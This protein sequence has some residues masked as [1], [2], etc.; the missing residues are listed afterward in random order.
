MDATI[1]ISSTAIVK[2][3]TGN[4]TV[5]ISE[6][7]EAA[8]LQ[9]AVKYDVNTLKVVSCGAG[10]LASNAVINHAIPGVIY[11]VWDNN[12]PITGEGTIL[13]IEFVFTEDTAVNKTEVE[14][15]LDEEF[16]VKDKSRE[17]LDVNIV[18]GIVEKA[19]FG[20]VSRD[21]KVNVEDAYLIRLYSA[22]LFPF[23]EIQLTVGDVDGDGKINAVDANYIRRYSAKIIESFP[24]EEM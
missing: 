14:I 4:V 5:D 21:G 22:K 3:K 23:D 16:V 11:F 13:N 20:D 9:F 17:E 8:M 15:D 7:S 18:N 10:E 6:N 19:I 24:A 2:G 1:T 12:V